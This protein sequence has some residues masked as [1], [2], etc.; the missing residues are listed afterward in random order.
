MMNARALKSSA[1]LSRPTGLIDLE[2]TVPWQDVNT[3]AFEFKH[4][5]AGH[6]L[7]TLSAL[8]DLSEKMFDRPDYAFYLRG[9]EASLPLAE[10]KRRI[11]ERILDIGTNGQ[12]LSLHYI[13]EVDPAYAEVFDLLLADIEQLTGRPIRQEMTWGS[14]SVFM[15]APGLKVP[16]HFD[17][18]TNYL[19]QVEGEK[20]VRLYPPGLQTLS[21]EEI[22][23]FYHFNAFAGRFRDDLAT[24]GTPFVLTPG[25]AVHHPPL[26]PH[27]IV[28]G[29]EISISVAI[30]YVMPDM[31]RRAHVHQAN[32]CMRMLGLTPRPLG[33]S[34]FWDD[35]KVA[36]ME[37]LSM[38]NPR[39]HNEML[40]SGVRRLGAPFRAAKALRQRLARAGSTTASHAEG[41]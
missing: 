26:A 25:T 34:P 1:P 41:T 37:R 27:L 15:N 24:A 35:A 21:I 22:E 39:T 18:E 20:V 7:F 14:L 17:H 30:Y 5:L 13:D 32:Y 16:Y 28:N 4:R 6:P 23:D 31:E 36:F 8:A 33:Q 11:R 9:S 3:K 2:D 10:M 12:W 19:M 40:Y 38:A 29:D